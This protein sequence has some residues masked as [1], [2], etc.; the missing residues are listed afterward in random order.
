MTQ[1]PGRW[2]GKATCAGEFKIGDYVMEIFMGEEG[3]VTNTRDDMVDV[4]FQDGMGPVPF[5]CEHLYLLES[6]D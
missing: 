6:K 2:D 1:P 5:W 3:V 4:D